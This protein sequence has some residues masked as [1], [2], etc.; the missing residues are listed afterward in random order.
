[1]ERRQP[2]A[3]AGR[4]GHRRGAGSTPAGAP[5]PDQLAY[6]MYTSGSTGLPKGVMVPHR[7]LLDWLHALHRRVPFEADELVAQKT[8]SAFAI[9]VKELFAGLLAGVPQL[10]IGEDVVKDVPA[11]VRLLA[12][13]RVTRLYTFPSQL[14]AILAYAASQQ[15]A[16]PALRCL[17]ISIEPCPVE[18]LAQL[19]AQLPWSRAWYIY[20]CTELND[21]TYHDPGAP[22]GSSGFVPIGQPIAATRVLVLDSALRPLP[23]GVMGELYVDHPGMARGYLNQPALSAQRFLANPHGAPGSR[24]Y[25]TGDHGRWLDNGA[26]EFLG[27]RDQ[28]VKIR[29]YRVDLRQIEKVSTA[30]PDV[31]EASVTGWPPGSDSPQ[32]LAY[33]AP[34][35][36]RTLD[37]EALRNYYAAALPTYMVPGLFQVLAA[38]PRLPNGKLDSQA[39]PPPDFGDSGAVFCA[40]SSATEIVLAAI[41]SEVLGQAGLAPPQVGLRDNFFNLGGHSLLATQLFSR[42]RQRFAVELPINTLFESPVLEDFA[43]AVDLALAAN[44][45][46]GVGAIVATHADNAPLSYAQERLWFVHQHMPEQRSSYNLAFSYHLHGAFDADDMA[47]GLNALVARHAVL[48]TRFVAGPDGIPRQLIAPDLTLQVPLLACDADAVEELAAQHA[49]APFDLA[50]GPLLK[51]SLLRLAPEHHVVLVNMHHIVADGWSIGILFRDLQ[52]C[53]AAAAGGTAA[54]LPA[55]AVQYADYAVWQRGRDL[56]AQLAYWTATLRDYEDGLALPYDFPR[57]PKRAWRAAV[58]HCRYPAALSARA[59]ELSQSQQSTLFITLLASFA[60]VLHQYTRRDDLCVGTTVAGRSHVELEPLIGCF[61]NILALRI[62]LSGNPSAATIFAR[63]R[64]RVLEGF[65]HQDL[66]FE[67]VVGALQ[68][69]RDS[70]QIPLVPLM[71]RHQ[72]F[73]LANLDGNGQDQ[74]AGEV[75]FGARST[76]SELDLQF[77]GDGASLELSAEYASE[78]F[79]A[80]TVATLVAQHQRVLAAMLD[81]PDMPLDQLAPGLPPQPEPALAGL[82]QEL[83]IVAQFERRAAATPQAPACAGAGTDTRLDYQTLN[84]R[85]NQLA[86]LLIEHAVGHETRVGLHLARGADLLVAM[87]AVLKAGGCYVPL[88]PHQPDGYLRQIVA[89]AR[90]LLVLTAAAGDAPEIGAAALLVLDQTALAQRPDT[91]PARPANPDQLAYVMYTSGST[92]VPKGVMVPQRQLLTWLPALAQRIPFEAHDVVAQKTASAFAVSVKEMFGALLA[93][94][95]QYFI[96]DA[97]VRDSAALARALAAGA[98]TRFYTL[99]SQLDALLSHMAA[100]GARLPLLRQLIVAMEPLPAELLARLARLMPQAKLWYNYGCT[101]LNDISY[102]DP[103]AALGHS[104]FVPIGRPIAG[105][106]VL[107]LDE[108]MRCVPPGA[109][110]ELYVESPSCARGYAG[111]PGLSAERFV[112]NP[113]GPAGSRLYRTGDLARLLSDGALECMGRRDS[114]VKIRGYRV[115]LRQVELAALAHPMVREA[116]V[117][118]WPSP[119]GQLQLAAYLAPH[120]GQQLDGPALRHYLGERLPTYMVPTLLTIL[121]EL[122]RLQNGKLDRLS[123]PAPHSQQAAGARASQAG[124]QAPQSD[125]E[126]ALADLWSELLVQGGAGAAPISVDDNFFDLGGHSLLASQ[127]A[128]RVRSQFGVELAVATLFEAPLLGAYAAALD[129]AMAHGGGQHAAGRQAA[130]VPLAQGAGTAPLFCVAP[131]GGQVFHYRELARALS[132][133]ASVFGLGVDEGAR[134]ASL[135]ALAVHHADTVQRCQPSGPYRLLGWSSGGLIALALGAELERRGATVDYLGLLDTQLIPAAALEAGR[136]AAV[137]AMN[138]LGGLRQRNLERAEMDQVLA[139]LEAQ[140]W[141]EQAFEPAQCGESLRALAEHLDVRLDARTL[142][143]LQARLQATRAALELLAGWRPAAADARNR[144]LY[145]VGAAAATELAIAP[146]RR[147]AAAGDHYSMLAGAHALALGEQIASDMARHASLAGDAPEPCA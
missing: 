68:K 120:A 10:F 138:L 87:L 115:D 81:A 41:W 84:R 55:L 14:S 126:L 114:E 146:A 1:M 16:L 5:Q 91:N 17:F 11:L 70:S 56:G 135:E 124:Y 12:A 27:R 119:S 90:P 133:S 15:L 142:P 130:A 131:L 58:H 92:G 94:V 125:T 88:E 2:G 141:D 86:H 118:G 144:V 137:A 101:E 66:P 96:D 51:V 23:V 132:A 9:S 112:A 69:Q 117:T 26:L 113:Y 123:L 140:G 64:A 48:R 107:L 28:E 110:G 102:S 43:R 60:V 111:Q 7:Q 122:P 71:L 25:K 79:D 99:P 104:G 74:R 127:M 65:E 73:P 34:Q 24:L 106:R 39:L 45:P 136:L 4:P 21:M 82:G 37:I 53:Q 63:T 52:A 40:P 38:L 95:P 3:G 62:D 77:T 100:S 32:L 31:A 47:A 61:V 108:T 128:T 13:Q 97:T 78:L 76:A 67:Q 6:I 8:S 59:A 19:Q 35:P 93:G 22:L 103:G 57:P 50:A 147:R 75:R 116:A 30:H 80:S 139:W 105:S 129:A 134:H 33:L 18:L 20:G 145:Q 44:T 121:P 72:N 83:G 49:A 85:A 36:G 46:A 143:Q 29:G 98:V 54:Q 109:T 89:D 42:M